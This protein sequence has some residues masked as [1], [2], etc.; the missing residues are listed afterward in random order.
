MT[1]V[2]CCK[3]GL[4]LTKYWNGKESRL[5]IEYQGKQLDIPVYLLPEPIIRAIIHLAR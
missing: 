5:E 1:S 3:K 2:I 4:K